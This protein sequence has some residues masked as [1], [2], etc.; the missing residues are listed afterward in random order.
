MDMPHGITSRF[1]NILPVK[2]PPPFEGGGQGVVLIEREY[3]G[4]NVLSR[5]TPQF[6]DAHKFERILSHGA[7]NDRSRL[8]ELTSYRR[9]LDRRHRSRH[10]QNDPFTF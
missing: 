6:L 3:L 4:H 1:R 10:A 8:N 9:R 7:V 2:V 5:N